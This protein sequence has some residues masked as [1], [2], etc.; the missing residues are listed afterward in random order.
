MMAAITAALCLLLAVPAAT[1]G[2][3]LKWVLPL[4]VGPSAAAAGW[5][6]LPLPR[7]PLTELAASVALLL[8]VMVIFLSLAWRRIPDG[9]AG[10]AAACG[11]SPIQTLFYAR[12][13]PAVP[14]AL[15]GLGLVFV[16][17]LGLAPLLAPLAAS[18]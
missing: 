9:L 18:P 12:I 1:Q 3:P 8:P 14:A 17:A 13:R 4:A 11:A 15:G 2:A 6:L 10:T 16:L 5:A 7:E